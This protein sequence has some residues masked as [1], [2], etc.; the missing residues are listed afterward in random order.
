MGPEVI[1]TL[2]PIVALLIP[3]FAFYYDFKKEY[4]RRQE[5]IK[6]IEKGLEPPPEPVKP[7]LTP[8]DYLRRGILA[9]GIGVGFG[10]AG[11]ILSILNTITGYIFYSIGAVIFFA[12]LSLVV[13]Y[14]IKGREQ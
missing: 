14:I 7:P 8:A 6:A 12:G 3:I 9:I 10:I 5:R 11:G 13:F 2:I 4:V 1:A